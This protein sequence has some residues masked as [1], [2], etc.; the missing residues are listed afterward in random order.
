MLGSLNDMTMVW[1]DGLGRWLCFQLQFRYGHAGKW[2]MHHRYAQPG[3]CLAQPDTCMHQQYKQAD[4]HPHLRQT[5]VSIYSVRHVHCA[6]EPSYM[7]LH[8]QADRDMH[9]DTLI[10]V[11]PVCTLCASG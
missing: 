7:Q 8:R 9:T 6:N 10:H 11:W 5:A 3:T 2:H 1:A 4:T